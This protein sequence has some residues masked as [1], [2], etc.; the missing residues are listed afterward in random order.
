MYTHFPFPLPFWL[1]AFSPE[2]AREAH[3]KKNT[4]ARLSRPSPLDQELMLA[5]GHVFFVV[6][7]QL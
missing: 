2:P 3:L 1:K 7:A 6:V 5:Q 4:F